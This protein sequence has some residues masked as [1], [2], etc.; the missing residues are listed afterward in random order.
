MVGSKLK[1]PTITIE[2]TREIV[3]FLRDLHCLMKASHEYLD[4]SLE[5]LSLF[6]AL[7]MSAASIA[8]VRSDMLDFLPTDAYVITPQYFYIYLVGVYQ[9][10]KHIGDNIERYNVNPDVVEYLKQTYNHL[11]RCYLFAATAEYN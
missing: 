11:R 9:L 8:R 6:N 5:D 1:P 3:E 4:L 7:S 2:L 10:I